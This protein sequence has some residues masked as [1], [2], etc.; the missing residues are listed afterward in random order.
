MNNLKKGTEVETIK[1]LFLHSS[2]IVFILN[3]DFEILWC[4]KNDMLS[5]FGNDTFKNAFKDNDKPL[6]SGEYFFERNG[7]EFQANII[8]YP[9]QEVYIIQ[10]NND[11]TMF[12]FLKSNSV[13]SFF[14]NQEE[15]I[16]NAS[17][18]IFF[19]MTTIRNNIKEDEEKEY[20]DFFDAIS[21]N[22]HKM[23]IPITDTS[24]LIKYIQF[25]S[26]P[27]ALNVSYHLNK[28]VTICNNILKF[29]YK[30]FLNDESDLF[31]MTD[32][33]R[34]S[35]CIR[36]LI[37][38]TIRNNPGCHNIS[39]EVEKFGEYVSIIALSGEGKEHLHEMTKKKLFSSPYGYYDKNTI[40]LDVA[41]IHRFCNTYN[42]MFF[43][44]K[45]SDAKGNIYSLKLP[46]CEVPKNKNDKDDDNITFKS[47][48]VQ[49]DSAMFTKY[50]IALS[51]IADTFK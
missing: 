38:L 14:K 23:L 16:R 20:A 19:A 4:N 47:S 43:S 35:S 17:S 49:E 21:G 27:S 12:S 7:F 2:E 3:Y 40:D 44:Q 48:V 6:K 10:T 13:R 45:T 42:G 26:E 51:K 41:I 46:C 9:A 50:R 32:S 25:A 8:N 29:Q 34:F 24:E 1:N 39:I 37:V 5:I 28:I 18:G 15:Q 30:I 36:S 33:E 22:C 11:D 31:I